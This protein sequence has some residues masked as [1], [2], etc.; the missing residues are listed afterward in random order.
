MVVTFRATDVVLDSAS[1]P[2]Y[3]RSFCRFVSK[4]TV[5]FLHIH[6]MP[7][8]LHRAL[9]MTQKTLQVRESQILTPSR[10]LWDRYYMTLY[11]KYHNILR[12]KRTTLNT[13]NHGLC[14]YDFI[15]VQLFDI[16]WTTWQPFPSTR[17]YV[18]LLLVYRGYWYYMIPIVHC[19][20]LLYL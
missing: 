1:V 3:T 19:F 8:Q 4:M 2:H 7:L 17:S 9:P 18:I 11:N 5:W 12:Q 15:H 13:Q 20:S 14:H 16:T 10:C 6:Q